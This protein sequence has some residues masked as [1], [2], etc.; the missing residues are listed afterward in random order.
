MLRGPPLLATLSHEQATCLN[1]KL[2]AL[3]HQK[4]PKWRLIGHPSKV[5]SAKQWY[6][7]GPHPV[8][9][10]RSCSFPECMVLRCSESLADQ[11][12]DD[13]LVNVPNKTKLSLGIKQSFALVA[14]MVKAHSCL[15]IDFQV[16][17]RNDGTVLNIDLDR[18]DDPISKEEKIKL[19][20]GQFHMCSRLSYSLNRIRF[21]NELRMSVESRHLTHSRQG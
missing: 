6:A 20:D 11:A 2:Q 10:V 12:V 7:T 5:D 1:A 21:E 18:C 9:A 17:L 13:F 3:D 14:A 19:A 16:Y 8:Q 15:K 4:H